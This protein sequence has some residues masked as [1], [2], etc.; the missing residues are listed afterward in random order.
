MLE[1]LR[2]RCLTP[3]VTD[4]KIVK[5]T[6]PCATST[7]LDSKSSFHFR[8]CQLNRKWI[9][10]R[11]NAIRDALR[12]TILDVSKSEKHNP[13]LKMEFDLAYTIPARANQMKKADLVY[14]Q[15]KGTH[16]RAIDI[17]VVDASAKTYLEKHHS[18]ERQVLQQKSWRNQSAKSTEVL[19]TWL[20]VDILFPLSWRLLDAWGQQQP[21]FLM[22]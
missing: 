5:W 15:V 13:N 9:V 21:I 2:T 19:A 10:Y 3:P 17:S 7:D 4:S 1:S 22:I 12:D 14:T 18:H 20:K 11:H 16:L 8:T 6:C